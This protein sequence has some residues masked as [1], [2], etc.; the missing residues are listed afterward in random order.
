MIRKHKIGDHDRP[1]FVTCTIVVWIDLFIRNQYREIFISEIKRQQIDNGLLIYAY[2]IM[3]SH[4]HLII[5][6]RST[7]PL[8]RLVGSIKAC[9]SKLIKELIVALEILR[10]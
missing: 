5:G 3:P 4:V 10:G 1:H 9:S 2:C 6:R 8:D 7:V